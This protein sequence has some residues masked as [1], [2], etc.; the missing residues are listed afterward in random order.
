MLLKEFLR[1]LSFE[2][3]K[4]N[5]TQSF[6]MKDIYMLGED[7]HEELE[8]GESLVSITGNLGFEKQ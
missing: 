5:D 4:R 2:V 7:E 8:V 1:K 6:A 3:N